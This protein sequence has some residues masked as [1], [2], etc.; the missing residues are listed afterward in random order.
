M[1]VVQEASQVGG[2]F[3]DQTLVTPLEEF[4]VYLPVAVIAVRKRRLELLHA[5]DQIPLWRAHH[6]VEVI[7]HHAKSLQQPTALFTRFEQADFKRPVGAFIHKQI[8]T[9]V[10][11]IDQVVDPVLPFNS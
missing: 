7:G 3:H 1:Y 2:L 4:A 6:Q 10:P 11:P 8:L 9:V 5:I